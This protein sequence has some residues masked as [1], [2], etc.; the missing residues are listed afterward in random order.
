VNPFHSDTAALGY[1][2]EADDLYL[3]DYFINFPNDNYDELLEQLDTLLIGD[4]DPNFF[5]E[6]VLN[7]LA[8]LN[9]FEIGLFVC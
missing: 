7:L 5:Y 4:D 1:F 8:A 2:L 6:D 3:L 9:R